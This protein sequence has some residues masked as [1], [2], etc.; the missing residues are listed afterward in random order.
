VI[1][2]VDA[3]RVGIAD[4]YQNLAIL[5][6]SLGEFAPALQGQLFEQYGIADPDRRKLQFHLMLDELF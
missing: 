5:W 6:N 3:A 2:C 4:R 1:G